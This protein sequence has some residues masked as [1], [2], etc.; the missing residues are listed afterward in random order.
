M[1]ASLT[2]MFVMVAGVFCTCSTA[3]AQQPAVAASVDEHACCTPHKHDPAAPSQHQDHCAHCG[4]LVVVP[5]HAP[6]HVLDLTLAQFVTP[7]VAP[8]IFAELATRAF[9][10]IAFGS[11]SPP[12]LLSLCCALRL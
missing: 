2:A 11:A 3:A 5:A 7:C 4:H 8:A 10:P 6:D 9:A 1:I 12:D